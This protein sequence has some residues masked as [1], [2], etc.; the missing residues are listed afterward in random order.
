MHS[1]V[2]IVYIIYIYMHTWSCMH[3]TVLTLRVHACTLIEDLE[4]NPEQRDQPEQD[5]R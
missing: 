2:Y 3:W 1:F 5:L 4:V